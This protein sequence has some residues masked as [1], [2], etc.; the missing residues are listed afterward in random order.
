MKLLFYI[1]RV[2]AFFYNKFFDSNGMNGEFMSQEE[3][4][5]LLISSDKSLIRWG[6]GESII[7]S[8]GSLYFQK[9]SFYLM[10][11]FFTLVNNYNSSSK[12]LIALP[13][14]Y[15]KDK[16]S[17]LIEKNSYRTWKYTRYIYQLFFR[18]DNIYLDAFLFRENTRLLNEKIELLWMKKKV[19]FFVHN[20]FKYYH[21]FEKKY[22]EKSIYFIQINNSNSYQQIPTTINKI[23]NIIKN[24]NLKK[25]E[26]IV[27]ISAG[28]A[29]KVLVF[30]LVNIDLKALDMGHYFDYKF[31][32]IK[33]DYKKD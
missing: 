9:N 23:T 11:D 12:Y 28:P 31:Y 33:R 32:G 19:I 13:H 29:G 10:K 2:C 8:G 22:S 1:H 16:K 5:E 27:L 3:S 7:A 15:L 26:I 6:D 24:N 4:L 18:K 25:E 17:H 21:D 20:N 30:K 14:V